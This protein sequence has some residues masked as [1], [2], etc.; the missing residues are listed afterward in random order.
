M[1]PK[2]FDPEGSDYD[3]ETAKIGGLGPDG[4]GDNKGHWGS[5]TMAS[6]AE[7]KLHGLPSDSYV[8]LKG[9]KHETWDK[10]E[11]AEKARGSEI[12]KRGERYY[13]V[14]VKKKKGGIISASK[15]ADG[16]AV[17]GKT[18]GRFV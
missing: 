18:K 16:C 3:Y 11:E 2:T 12:I 10:A 13:S 7:K 8:I 15:R 17:K 14:P 6:D 4:T 5:V 1:P 9:R